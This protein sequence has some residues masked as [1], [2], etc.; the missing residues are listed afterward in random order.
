MSDSSEY[1]VLSVNRTKNPE[2]GDVSMR[3]MEGLVRGSLM[4]DPRPGGP[5]T[6]GDCQRDLRPCYVQ[7]GIFLVAGASAKDNEDRDQSSTV[8]AT[9][10]DLTG[11]Q[12]K[13]QLNAGGSH[14]LSRR[15]ATSPVVTACSV[16][17]P[18]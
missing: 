14:R 18:F 7:N 15:A 6:M 2:L 12:V 16:Y 4:P 11:S 17:L 5:L 1:L 9:G 3:H 8:P 13:N 10:W